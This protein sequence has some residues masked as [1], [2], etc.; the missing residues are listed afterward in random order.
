MLDER[1]I[2]I[3]RQM[4]AE[5][6]TR[7]DAKLAAMETRLNGRIDEK[8]AE[9][10]NHL[11]AYIEAKIEPQLQLLAE[12]QQAIREQMATKEQ[13]ERLETRIST[14]EHIVTQHSKDIKKLKEAI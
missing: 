4:F 3:L 6:D 2:E 14:L 12:G 11:F 10:E 5:Q 8:T 1:D 9:V 7:T 13:V